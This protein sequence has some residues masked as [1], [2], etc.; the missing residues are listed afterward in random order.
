MSFSRRSLGVGLLDSLTR[1]GLTFLLSF[2]TTT[3]V[4]K[5]NDVNRYGYLPYSLFI[6]YA[7][8]NFFSL[9]IVILGLLSFCRH[10]VFPDKK[11]QDIASAAGH[12]DIGQWSLSTFSCY[13]NS[14]IQ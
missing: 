1:A 7:L 3:T 2:N 11:F 4:T 14:A 10:G 6:P 12:P 13:A 9:I 8:A 5:W